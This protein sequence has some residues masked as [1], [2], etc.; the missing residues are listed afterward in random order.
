[1]S[2]YFSQF[3]DAVST[4]FNPAAFA[5]GKV[6]EY[7][8]S[9]T[10]AS[11]AAYDQIKA[12]WNGLLKWGAALPL[13]GD[14]LPAGWT[15]H[16]DVVAAIAHQYQSWQAFRTDWEERG[17]KDTTAL[18]GQASDLTVAENIAS[19]FG[20]PG[21][22][23]TRTTSTEPGYGTKNPVHTPDISQQTPA[24]GAATQFKNTADAASVAVGKAIPVL[25]NPAGSI[26]SQLSFGQ[27]VG[28]VALLSIGGFIGIKLATAA[29]TAPLP[30]VRIGGVP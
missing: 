17:V 13:P 26:W 27:K 22:Y 5:V 15:M 3:E 10:D 20:Y 25:T 16:P 24:Y 29:A 30:P 4:A 23:H 11:N 7:E 19:D 6:V 18:G 21:T 14:T 9:P 1:M 2:S 28:V 12:K 8:T